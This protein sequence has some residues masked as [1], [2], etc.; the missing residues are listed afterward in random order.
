MNPFGD[1]RAR[2]RFD[3]LGS[4]R[5][6]LELTEPADI[7]NISAHGALV[8]SRTRVA[9][10]SHQELSVNLDGFDA[11]VTARVSWLETVS[12]QFDTPTYKIGLDFLAPPAALA[13]TISR[14]TE[15][16]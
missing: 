8:E 7:I 4:L 9:L 16:S 5:G 10:G 13:E 11:R 1:R 14:L 2:A 3:V 12:G 15:R 6:T